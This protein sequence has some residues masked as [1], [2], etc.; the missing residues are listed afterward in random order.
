MGRWTDGGGDGGD[1]STAVVDVDK[2]EAKTKANVAAA[3]AAAKANGHEQ[4]P[5]NKGEHPDTIA[6][7]QPTAKGS[8][9]GYGQPDLASMKLNAKSYEH[10]IGLFKNAEFYPNFRPGD[11]HGSTDQSARTVIDQLKANLK[12]MYGFADKHSR[13]WYDGARALVDDRAKIFGFNDASIAGVY[14]A[15]S[16]TKDWDQNVHLGDM[17]MHTYKNQQNTRWSKEMDEKAKT[18]WSAKNQPIV[19]LVRGKTLGELKT[20]TEK[21]VWIRTYD[22]THGVPDYH[23]VLPDGRLGGLVRTKDGSPAKVVWQSLPSITNAIKALEANG[24]KEKLSAAMGSAHKVRSFYNNILDPHSAN[25]DVTIDTHAVGAALLRQLSNASVPVVQNFGSSLS[26]AE[27][28]EGYEAATSSTKTGLSGLYPVYAQAYREAAK[29]LGIQPRQ[30]QSA[31]WVVKR[32][33]F[34]NLTDKQK[35]AIEA[36]WRDHHDRPDKTLAETQAQ[37]AEISGLKHARRFDGDHEKGRHRGDAR[38][39]H[40]AGL[41]P[42]AAGVDRG[43]G[44]GA[45][46]RAARLVSV[47][48]PGRR[49]GSE[50]VTPNNQTV[51]AARASAR[52]F[53]RLR[54]GDAMPISPGKDEPR[55]NW[56]AR[57]VPEM[58]G[59]QGG[60]KRPQD[61]AVAACNQMWA[62]SHPHGDNKTLKQDFGSDDGNIDPEDIDAPE[63]DDDESQDDFMDRCVDQVMDDHDGVDEDTAENACQVAWEDARA[64]REG[65]RH[66][67]HIEA[68]A[69]DTREFTLSDESLDR[70]GDIIMSDGWQLESFQKNPIA[71]FNHSPNA[72]IGTWKN[73]RV[74]NKQLRGHLQLAPKGISPRI[75][76][77]RALVEAGILRAVSVGFRELESE[78]LKGEDGKHHWGMGYRFLKQ[79]LVETSLVSVPANVNALAVA[80]SLKISSQTLDLVFAKHGKRDRIKQREFAGKHAKRSRNGKGD[81]MSLSQRIVDLE[82]ALVAK[83]DALRQHLDEQDDSNVSDAQLQVTS[84]LNAEIIRLDRQ[85][86]MLVDS[87]RSL[88][89]TAD[90]GNGNGNPCGV[91][92]ALA[93]SGGREHLNGSTSFTPRRGEKDKKELGAMD[94]LI[95]AATVSYFTKTTGRLIHEVREKIYGDDELTKV[96][97]DLITRAPSAP[98]MMTVT[99]WAAELVHQIYTDFMQLLMPKSLLPGLAAKGMAL[100]FGANGRIIIPTRNRTPTLAGSFVGEGQAIP[101]RQGAFAS[102]TL[103]PKKVAVISSWT[104]EMNDHSIPAIEGLLREAVMVDTTVAIDTVLIDSNPAT[105][106]RPA[107]LLNGL[108]TLTPTAGGGL[109]AL[110]GDLKLLVQGL[111]AGTYG[112]IRAPVWLVNPGDML[113]AALTSA[114]NTGIFPFRDE[115]KQGTLGGIPFIESVT[116]PAHQMVLVD[117]ADFVVVGGEAPRLEISDQATLHLEDTSPADLVTGSPG[118]VATPQ[119][120]L[121][122]TDSLALRMVMPL[123]WVQRR[124]GTIV[125]MTG[126]T[127]S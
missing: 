107:G 22:Q 15:L 45:A 127:W 56:M 43:A 116:M 28:P 1:G 16:P 9:P 38:E 71:L 112:N 125:F 53:A 109:S 64:A 14:A 106:I 105:T 34:G 88:G 119:K 121:F 19:D 6:S 117:A 90:N 82:G 68:V 91:G 69:D 108:S 44:N 47:R 79:E 42:A 87:E 62:D 123:N 101:V 10:D 21:A 100:S 3:A 55:E 83:R 5:G 92:R 118:V 81:T 85:R 74:E 111:I 39:L 95:R 11:F 17:L 12:F 84:D 122:Q 40:R 76:E 41:G 98:A 52:D 20:A 96:A 7:R 89:Q 25:G 31:V 103:T 115:I 124:A 65:V 80:K 27:Q 60:T 70:M 8:T 102:Q 97:V 33:A 59:E 2:V 110:T 51:E 63:P 37:V 67:T 66:K 73:L 58:M 48:E 23:R 30:L 99:G 113:A 75:D 54:K 32:D 72:V 35:N 50:E 4:L 24:D 77:I 94:L 49:A 57:C 78:P 120:S 46:A 104:R 29:E 18:L 61:Q 114:A 36:A 86:A 93:L 126:T 13:V 26:R